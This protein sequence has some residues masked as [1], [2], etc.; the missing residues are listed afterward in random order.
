M[1]INKIIIRHIEG[2]KANQNDEFS[3]S[4]NN[5]ITLGRSADS[6]VQFDPESDNGVSRQHAVI[7]KGEA[8]GQF[9]IEDN[10]S[11]N[12]VF[13]NGEK[14]SSKTE[15][16]VG[17]NVQLGLK[18][19]KFSFDLDPRPIGAK[20]TELMQVYAATQE[21]AIDEVEAEL[22]QEPSKI[23]I[24]KETFERA[25]VEERKRST[26]NVAAMLIGG[27]LIA[28][29]LAFAFRDQWLPEPPPP[30]EPPIID[31][32]KQFDAAAIAE[33]N[34][35]KLVLIE[36]GWKLAHG[37]LGD[38][39]YHEYTIQ[40]DPKTK[41]KYSVAVYLEASPGIIEPLLGLRR[42]VPNGEP[43]ASGGT[44]T[45]FVIDE[46]GHIMTNKHV[47]S[48]WKLMPYN[49][50]QSAQEGILLRSVNGKWEN[51]GKV[52]APRNWIPG[53]TK[54]FGKEPISGTGITAEITYMDV[55]FAKTSQRTKAKITRESPE[56]DLAILK[57]DLVGDLAPV[58]FAQTYSNIRM[59]DQIISMGFPGLSPD[60]VK[61]TKDQ[62]DQSKSYK[63]VPSPTL[64]DGRISKIIDSSAD[65]S[66]ANTDDI[67]S[68]QGETYQ[69]TIN[70]GSGNSGGP[71]FNKEGEVI[72]ILNSTRADFS[73]T[74]FTYAVPAKYALKLMGTQTVIK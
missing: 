4:K 26:F 10:N 24:G 44:G 37:Q 2:S 58:K 63:V 30:V 66:L 50:P 69:M 72:A 18:G 46:K 35:N 60:V 16:F 23:G 12:G 27:L 13:V 48:S 36:T 52:R 57:I 17:D 15:L 64:A 32:P 49:F 40:E 5:T 73:S 42:N 68:W 67:Y 65:A 51:V 7:T 71:V 25:I 74:K 11:L 1:K 22:I 34:M 53:N 21:I 31:I 3:F 39:I 54:L 14:I 55:T 33:A 38:D 62:S 41:E 70:T 19:P 43:I 56:H 8:N 29:A 59:G 9:F 20:A 6:N 47:S 45:G 28:A 61:V